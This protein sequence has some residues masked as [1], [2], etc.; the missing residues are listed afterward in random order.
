[1]DTVSQSETTSPNAANSVGGKTRGIIPYQFKPGQ[2][3]NPNGRP[4]KIQA[5]ANVAEEA[6]ERAMR[7]LSNLIDS[8][9]E[10][11]ALAA[12]QAIIDRA[13]GKPKQTL[14]IAK[15]KRTLDELD[16][17]DLIAAVHESGDSE[18]ATSPEA[19]D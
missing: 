13:M 7:K 12:S 18:G 14:D 8:E 6:T 16:T 10:K 3:G 4:K 19:R 5:A 1:M 15:T 11:V 9:D 2:S 17:D